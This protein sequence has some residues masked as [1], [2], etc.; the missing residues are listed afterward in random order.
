MKDTPLL[1][2]A[3]TSGSVTVSRKSFLRRWWNLTTDP[4][5][6]TVGNVKRSYWPW[7]WPLY[8]V[9]FWRLQLARVP[10]FIATLVF[11][12]LPQRYVF[13]DVAQAF[14]LS[15]YVCCFWSWDIV[16]G[17]MN[18]VLWVADALP[19]AILLITFL[20][21]LGTHTVGLIICLV[22]LI[23][24]FSLMDGPNAIWL[25]TWGGLTVLAAT[26]IDYNSAITYHSLE[27]VLDNA[28]QGTCMVDRYS[29]DIVSAGRRMQQLLAFRTN[30]FDLVI[31]ED[32]ETLAKFLLRVNKSSKR[33][34]VMITSGPRNSEF[35]ANIIPYKVSSTEITLCV[36][37]VGEVASA[38]TV[39]SIGPSAQK[40]SHM[41][42]APVEGVRTADADFVNSTRLA[43]Y[44]RQATLADTKQMEIHVQ[45]V[46]TPEQMAMNLSKDV[47]DPRA[48]ETINV[49]VDLVCNKSKGGGLVAIVPREGF[50]AMLDEG[51]ASIFCSDG[52]YMTRRLRG[53]HVTDPEFEEAFVSFT[54]H[55]SND[56]W[57]KDHPDLEARNQPKDGAFVVDFSGMRL[58][59][60]AKLGGMKPPGRWAGVGTKHDAAQSTAWHCDG[61]V[62]LVKSDSGK[63]HGLR[64]NRETDELCVYECKG[65][66]A[67]KSVGMISRC[68]VL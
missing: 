28:T 16:H 65:P 6:M 11:S 23:I 4:M 62:V 22:A 38:Q 31:E 35:E 56:L 45:P 34:C 30:I 19:Y 1:Q 46:E 27:K 63:I 37:L 9:F 17:D 33:L 39:P 3:G 36:Q 48:L 18:D 2:M 20:A 24:K 50:Q 68:T 8:G 13:S 26:L 12:R 10:I 51:R 29:G 15:I 52:N 43:R 40:T 58:K 49:V 60:A 54:E 25:A 66:E 44:S 14:F 42:N 41:P 57:P 21:F 32:R 7:I 53:V 61:A 67:M 5:Y 55:T 47:S 64:R 59:C